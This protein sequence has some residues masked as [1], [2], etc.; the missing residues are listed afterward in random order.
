MK[1]KIRSFLKHKI[2]MVQCRSLSLDWSKH[3]VLFT[4]ILNFRHILVL[5]NLLVTHNQ[6]K[7]ELSF[8]VFTFSA[9]KL[10]CK[11][12]MA[13]NELAIQLK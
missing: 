4:K 9:I 6:T 1:E 5:Y 2:S 11:P 3:K 8:P 7:T 13:F 12:N 10:N